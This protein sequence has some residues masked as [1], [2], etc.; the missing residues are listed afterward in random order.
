MKKVLDTKAAKLARMAERGGTE[1]ERAVA[2]AKLQ[3][4]ASVPAKVA[5]EEASDI[6]LPMGQLIRIRGN[7]RT[8]L[9]QTA[10]KHFL[11]HIKNKQE[12]NNRSIPLTDDFG[13]GDFY[14]ILSWLLKCNLCIKRGS[15]YEIPN[16]AT[17]V[18]M[19]NLSVD[20]MK[21]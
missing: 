3:S 16:K 18:A 4:F 11:Q 10:L 21:L 20:S 2:K 19:W 14:V 9:R 5:P 1:N 12:F 17:V 7:S 8:F 15:R 13:T 6:W